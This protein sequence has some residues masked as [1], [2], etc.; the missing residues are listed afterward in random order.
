MALAHVI[1]RVDS[2]PL[3]PPRRLPRPVDISVVEQNQVALG[4]P[5]PLP[6]LLESLLDLSESRI[7]SSAGE[8]ETA[9]GLPRASLGPYRPGRV[10]DIQNESIVLLALV[11][12]ARQAQVGR[13]AVGRLGDTADPERSVDL[14]AG[15]NRHRAMLCQTI[16]E[17]GNQSFHVDDTFECHETRARASLVL[18]QVHVAVALKPVGDDVRQVPQALGSALDQA[19]EPLPRE[20]CQVRVTDRIHGCRAEVAGEK[21]HLTQYL[22]P[23]QLVEGSF[24]TVR[25]L[26]HHSQP[27]AHHDVGRVTRIPLPEE[28]LTTGDGQQ[29]H[30]GFQ[31]T[32][33]IQLVDLE[34]PEEL[35]QIRRELRLLHPLQ[36]HLRDL[37][38]GLRITLEELVEALAREGRQAAVLGRPH[39][40]GVG[41]PGEQRPHTQ[42]I[43]GCQLTDDACTTVRSSSAGYQT[44]LQDDEDAVDG[45]TQL[46]QDLAC[47]T[48]HLLEIADELA[49]LR[50]R[51]TSQ[52]LAAAPQ[53]QQLLQQTACPGV[54]DHPAC[55]T[56]CRYRPRV[57]EHPA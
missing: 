42:K 12:P 17:P 18:W 31:V 55:S 9:I 15:E 38:P 35:V 4:C 32:Q 16:R 6:P 40:R 25:S 53:L 22:S 45:L 28:G 46:D 54:I 48:A 3:Q 51:K 33:D 13:V 37:E 20:T 1:D 44:A 30:L 19:M 23:S 43:A 14:G 5:G 11:Q 50:L 49:H 47:A 41:A 52:M 34:G 10:G 29:L 57:D 39:H 7:P 27:P 24:R 56:T 26:Q 36:D 8:V 21:R 2:T